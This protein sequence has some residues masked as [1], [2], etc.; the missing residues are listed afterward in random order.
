MQCDHDIPTGDHTLHILCHYIDL[1][2]GDIHNYLNTWAIQHMTWIKSIS[3]NIL[4]KKNLPLSDYL[5][6]MSTSGVPLDEIGILIV[7]SQSCYTDERTLL[8]PIK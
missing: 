2:P 1:T 6:N 4:R 8:V 7:R 5:L 3:Q